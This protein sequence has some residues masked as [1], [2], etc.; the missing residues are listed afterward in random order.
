VEEIRQAVAAWLMTADER[1]VWTVLGL[2]AATSLLCL[3]WAGKG[4]CKL[5]GRAFKGREEH[6]AV[7]RVLAALAGDVRATAGDKHVT[8]LEGSGTRVSIYHGQAGDALSTVFMAG[9]PVEML[10]DAAEQARILKAA[11]AAKARLDREAEAAKAGRERKAKLDAEAKR[12]ADRAALADLL[13]GRKG[14]DACP[15][16]AGCGADPCPKRNA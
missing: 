5:C 15:C 7:A 9:T 11:K 14:G 8:A 6:P 10:L 16:G 4:A 3:F 2:K 13:A 1:L 12:L